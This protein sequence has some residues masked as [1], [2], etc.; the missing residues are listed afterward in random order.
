MLEGGMHWGWL[1]DNMQEGRRMLSK[2]EGRGETCDTKQ[3][4]IS[5]HP[6]LKVRFEQRLKGV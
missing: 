2:G 4:D 5:T 3:E 1:E 6:L